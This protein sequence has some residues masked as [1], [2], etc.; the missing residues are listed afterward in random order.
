MELSADFKRALRLFVYYYFNGTLAYLVKDGQL[1]SEVD[2][3]VQLANQPSDE[4][5]GTIHYCCMS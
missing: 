5:S 4:S 3:A 2:Y 1:L